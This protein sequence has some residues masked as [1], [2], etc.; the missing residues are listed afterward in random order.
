[1]S[2]PPPGYNPEESVLSGG[3]GA[4]IMPV[5]GGGGDISGAAVGTSGAAVGTSGGTSEAAPTK[6]ELASVLGTETTDVSLKEAHDIMAT[7]TP[8]EKE[9]AQKAVLEAEQHLE[10]NPA[11]ETDGL[12][13][14]GGLSPA[15]KQKIL[16]NVAIEAIK[17][18][19][20]EAGTPVQIGEVEAA[21]T[22]LTKKVKKG[23]R[24]IENVD[25][26]PVN[27]ES[28][29][30]TDTTAL[31]MVS[32]ID[33]VYIEKFS[34]EIKNRFKTYMKDSMYTWN[35][36][37]YTN[38][39]SQKVAPNKPVI[40][41]GENITLNLFSKVLHILPIDTAEI[42][43]I[44]PINGDFSKFSNI[45]ETLILQ[46]IIEEKGIDPVYKN[47]PTL[48]VKYGTVIVFSSPFYGQ[49]TPV[50]KSLLLAFLRMKANSPSQ[51]FVLCD[52]TIEGYAQSVQLNRVYTSSPILLTMLEPSYVIYP[53]KRVGV[54]GIFITHSRDPGLPPPTDPKLYTNLAEYLASIYKQKTATIIY[55]T[56]EGESQIKDYS[57]I[58]SDTDKEPKIEGGVLEVGAKSQDPAKIIKFKLKE[59]VTFSGK[60]TL[61]FIRSLEAND[62]PREVKQRTIELN[63]NYYDIRIADPYHNNVFDNWLHTLYT[64]D[65]ANLLNEMNLRPYL[66]PRIFTETTWVEE[67]A[68]FLKNIGLSNCFTDESIMTRRE[69]QKSRD[70]IRTVMEYYALNGIT[71]EKLEDVEDQA[72]E[73]QTKILEGDIEK[74]LKLPL[75]SSAET[76]KQNQYKYIANIVS[77]KKYYILTA[78]NTKTGNQEYRRIE[79]NIDVEGEAAQ[80]F[81][82]T[83]LEELRS[84]NPHY[85]L[86]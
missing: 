11:A 63:G 26:D 36:L 43:V 69:C 27:V 62:D 78:M 16:A 68:S 17:K 51:V 40:K 60:K 28:I 39:T 33:P 31:T 75:A 41:E 4:K 81:I 20:A 14:A 19:R 10:M 22:N 24:S 82:K 59:P 32:S 2:A 5:Q 21:Y 66:L 9:I 13:Q 7:A 48:T 67:V 38:P 85:I 72:K 37:V 84:K 74:N 3:E 86:Y 18:K 56:A 80:N 49:T 23:P 34:R 53:H 12:V 15:E 76:Q 58:L 1:M 71:D 54:N 55:K 83:K 25:K 47:S 44:P 57:E 50:N 8:E 61:L 46:R 42:V 6:N 64:E 52:P 77:N 35:T 79:F 70:F 29:P 45:Y 73:E 30:I 65:E